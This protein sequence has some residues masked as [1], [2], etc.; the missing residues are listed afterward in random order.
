M[1]K[2]ALLVT[3]SVFSSAALIACDSDGGKKE[4]KKTDAKK[5]DAK[6]PEV[7][8]D[9][10]KD[11]SGVLARTASVLETSELISKDD[12]LRDA[13]KKLGA[14]PGVPTGGR[15]RRQE[16]EIRRVAAFEVNVHPSPTCW[17]LT[18]RRVAGRSGWSVCSRSCC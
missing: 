15:V 8:F 9:V 12:P 14:A 13:V 7:H 5:A 1:R 17:P 10:S 4:A 16:L 18:C 11:K 2:L 3:L 6:A